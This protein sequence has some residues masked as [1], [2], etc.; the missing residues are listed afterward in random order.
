M[1]FIY[2]Q[3]VVFSPDFKNFPSSLGTYVRHP[4]LWDGIP[5]DVVNKTCLYLEDHP[6]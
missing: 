4:G 3:T 6:S 1:G 5:E 2:I